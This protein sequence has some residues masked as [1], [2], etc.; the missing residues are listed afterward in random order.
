VNTNIFIYV[1]AAISNGIAVF[2]NLYKEEENNHEKESS[3]YKHLHRS[4][5][6]SS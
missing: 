5:F 4:R 3:F 6:C 1:E 2:Y